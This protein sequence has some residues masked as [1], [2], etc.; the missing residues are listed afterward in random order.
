MTKMEALR[1]PHNTERFSRGPRAPT[2][3]SHAHL[4]ESFPAVNPGGQNLLNNDCMGATGERGG[5][6][7][8]RFLELPVP[9]VLAILWLAGAAIISLGGL[10]FYLFWLSLWW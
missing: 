1:V 2:M 4:I 7:Y 6:A 8:W 5:G 10:P 3:P 9:M